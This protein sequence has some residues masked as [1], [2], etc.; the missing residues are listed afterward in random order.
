M[1]SAGELPHKAIIHVAG[2]NML[3]RSSEQS[4]RLSVSNATARARE[5]GFASVAMPLIGAGTGGRRGERALEFITDELS[6]VEFDGEV[7]V[8]RFRDA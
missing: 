7:R 2:I 3:W 6:K 4:I 5:H 8:V 1:T